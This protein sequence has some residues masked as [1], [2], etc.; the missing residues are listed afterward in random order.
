MP[1]HEAVAEAKTHH[2]GNETGALA[3]QSS[4]ARTWNNTSRWCPSARHTSREQVGALGET[5]KKSGSR[6]ESN[7]GMPEMCE[8]G[9]SRPIGASR[10]LRALR[11]GTA[12][13]RAS[14]R[15]RDELFSAGEP[16]TKSAGARCGRARTSRVS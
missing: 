2:G 9:F 13:Y 11:E 1:I 15:S 5:A 6:C 16:A 10:A 14:G 3:V 7:L 4:A 8:R 12:G